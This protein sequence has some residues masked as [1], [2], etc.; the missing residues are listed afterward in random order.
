MPRSTT[1]VCPGWSGTRSWSRSSIDLQRIAVLQIAL[2]DLV[3]QR[4]PLPV[5]HQPHHHLLAVRAV[6]ARVPALRL[7]VA[8][9]LPLEV[10]RGQVVEEDGVRRS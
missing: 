8:Q 3:R 2:E 1:T 10:R 6:I 4:K 7:G 5:D 9:R